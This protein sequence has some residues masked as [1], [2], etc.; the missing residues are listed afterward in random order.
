MFQLT[1]IKMIDVAVVG[2]VKHDFEERVE[3]VAVTQTRLL[4]ST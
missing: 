2:R 3:V 4:V 1:G